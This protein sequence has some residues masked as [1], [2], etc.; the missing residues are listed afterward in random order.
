MAYGTPPYIGTLQAV[1]SERVTQLGQPRK[2][3]EGYQPSREVIWR[4]SS[5]ALNAV[6]STRYGCLLVTHSSPSLLTINPSTL[7]MCDLSKPIVRET[8]DSVQFNPDAFTVSEKARKAKASPRIEEL[9]QP[10][11]RGT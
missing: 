4:V 2:Y 6:P 10:I 11:K 7:R 3:T 8:M 9:A 5:G 1:P